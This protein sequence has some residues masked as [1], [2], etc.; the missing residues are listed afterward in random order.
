MRA[1]RGERDRWT[2]RG[3]AVAGFA[4]SACAGVNDGTATAAGGGAHG[5]SAERRDAEDASERTVLRERALR[6]A[7]R[8]TDEH[9]WTTAAIDA[10]LRDLK[11]SP[12]MRACVRADGRAGGDASELGGELVGYFEEALDVAFH[13]KVV[14]ERERMRT[15]TSRERVKWMIQTRLEMIGA[16]LESWPKALAALATPTH[17]AATFRR[18]SALADFIADAS[19]VD[20]VD[21]LPEIVDGVRHHVE[22]ATIALTYAVIELRLLVDTSEDNRE[23]W[24]FLSR[25]VDDVAAR[26]VDVLELK[27]YLDVFAR[28]LDVPAAVARVGD[29]AASSVFRAL[30]ALV[31]RRAPPSAPS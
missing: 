1:T 16:K 31:R 26:R 13:A 29:T 18:R 22:R 10:G 25:L 8:R 17:A 24:A 9:G 2:A 4:A 14:A 21:S 11:L 30:V 28:D 3:R 15:M 23:T 6:A 20:D 5:A 19:G 12:A 27:S 7:L